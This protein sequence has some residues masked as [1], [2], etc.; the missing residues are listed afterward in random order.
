MMLALGHGH[1]KA[2]RLLLFSLGRDGQQLQNAPAAWADPEDFS[3]KADA[4][5]S[6]RTMR[7]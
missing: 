5:A 7:A 2:A 6:I 1:G 4:A 3:T